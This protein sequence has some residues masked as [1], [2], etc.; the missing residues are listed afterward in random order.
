MICQSN[1]EGCWGPLCF[2]SCKP[3]LT[4]GLLGDVLE[5]LTSTYAGQERRSWWEC[6]KGKSGLRWTRSRRGRGGEGGDSWIFAEEMARL[7]SLTLP[8]GGDW[9]NALL[10]GF[11]CDSRSKGRH[12]LKKNVF[13]WALP[14]SPDPLPPHPGNL[15]LFFGRQKQRFLWTLILGHFCNA[16]YDDEFKDRYLVFY[17]TS[18]LSS[19]ERHIFVKK[20]PQAITPSS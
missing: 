16:W 13:F 12:Q 8:H 5:A 3:P 7:K 20:I 15:V 4:R 9:V 6:P 1:N 14:E 18:V 10:W 17:K 2:C 11:T 19:S